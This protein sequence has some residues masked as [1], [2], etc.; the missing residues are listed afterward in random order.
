MTVK[1]IEIFL[2]LYKAQKDLMIH[3][4]K[5]RSNASTL[6]LT[7][8]VVLIGFIRI[9]NLT[10]SDYLTAGIIVLIGILG[11]V[12]SLK[13][14]ER[15]RYHLFSSQKCRF[16]ID[17][18]L[19]CGEL[20]NCEDQKI[21]DEIRKYFKLDPDS[22]NYLIQSIA[23]AAEIEYQQQR[24]Y[25]GRLAKLRLHHFWLVPHLLTSLI[26]IVIIVIIYKST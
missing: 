11:C 8:A 6:L 4:E 25:L 17:A 5:Q 14:Y 20:N 18:A 12:F 23:D 26:G 22:S 7:V 2:E 9:D 16:A 13:E 1:D 24:N 10:R 15:F 21:R 19:R 3:H